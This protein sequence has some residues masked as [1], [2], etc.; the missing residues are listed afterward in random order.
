MLPCPVINAIVSTASVACRLTSASLFFFRTA[1]AIS[2]RS[3][4]NDLG[5]YMQVIMEGLPMSEAEKQE[6]VQYICDKY[7][8]RI[9]DKVF[10]NADASSVS[11]RCEY[12]IPRP[13]AKMGGYYIGDPATWNQAKQAELRDSL[14]NPIV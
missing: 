3:R 14:P 9:I 8:D 12:H 11:I 10:L 4:Y 7:S 2:P 6:Y 5:D 13:I 1:I